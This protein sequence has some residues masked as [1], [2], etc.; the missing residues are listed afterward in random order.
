MVRLTLLHGFAGYLRLYSAILL[1]Y[2]QALRY[3]EDP[4]AEENVLIALGLRAESLPSTYQHCVSGS[5][6]KPYCFDLSSCCCK[7]VMLARPCSTA[8]WYAIF[9]LII[10]SC[11]FHVLVFEHLIPQGAVGY[12]VFI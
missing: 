2:P 5:R 1:F 7:F 4:A 8:E 6:T 10:Y 11:T 9:I 3:R 12:F